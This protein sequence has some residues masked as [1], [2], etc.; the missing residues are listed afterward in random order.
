MTDQWTC[1]HTAGA[2]CAQCYTELAAKAAA[3]QAEVD[4][5]ETAI[6]MAESAFRKNRSRMHVLHILRGYLKEDE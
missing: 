4:R 1:G 3:L 5:Y 6:Q 2:M